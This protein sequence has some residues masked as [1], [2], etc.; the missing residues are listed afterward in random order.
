MDINKEKY[1]FDDFV[2]IISILRSENGCPW[3]REQT[4]ESLRKNLIEES[5]E[6]IHEADANSKEGMCEELGDVLLQVVL[7]SQIAKDNGEFDINDVIDGIAKKMIFRH[8]HVFGDKKAKNVDEALSFFKQS[9]NKEKKLESKAEEIGHVPEDLPALMKSY[10]MFSHLEK[11]QP[12]CF[13][14]KFDDYM[15]KLEEEIAELKEAY[16]NMNI[17]NFEEELG[18]V[19]TMTVALGHTMAVDSEIALNKSFKKILNRIKIIE[20]LSKERGKKI[21]EITYTEF[22]EC[23]NMAKSEE[24]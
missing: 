20:K 21:D 12:N 4:H 7:H 18:D 5:Y 1:T 19:L 8:P 17:G 23:W 9:K 22:I 10:K 24:K 13:T 2:K 14:G 11:I 6:F 15:E 3:D 16:N